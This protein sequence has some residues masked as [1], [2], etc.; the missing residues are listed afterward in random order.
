[1]AGFTQKTIDFIKS[2]ISRRQDM[3]PLGEEKFALVV[4]G[5][6]EETFTVVK[7][8]TQGELNRCYRAEL[9]MVSRHPRLDIGKM[10]MSPA[11]AYIKRNEGTFVPFS[12]ILAELEE[13]KKVDDNIFYRAVFVPKLWLLTR[14]SSNRIFLDITIPKL[15]EEVLV[16]GG[17]TKNEFEFRLQ[18]EYPR[19]WEYVC[20]YGESHF[21][22]FSRWLEYAGMYFYLEPTDEGEKLII[23]DTRI[24]HTPPPFAT[25]LQYR[26]PAALET[27]HWDELLTDFRA[28]YASVPKSVTLKDYNYRRPS[29]ELTGAADISAN[30]AGEIFIYGEHFQTPE[31]A[32]RVAKIRAEEIS[33]RQTVFHGESRAPFLRPGFIF[34]VQGHYQEEYNRRYMVTDIEHHGN[35]ATFLTAG[36]RRELAEDEREPFYRNNF[37]A[38]PADVQYRPPRITPKPRF[39]GII[40]AHIDAE[41]SGEYAELDNQGRYKV[42]LPFDLSNR[43]GGKASAWFRMAQPYAGSKHGMHFPLLKGTEVLLAFIDGDPDRP[44]ITGAV[45]NPLNP[46]VINDESATKAGFITPGGSSL[47]ADDMAGK[48]QVALRQGNNAMITLRGSGLGS[49]AGTWS[50]YAWH[51]AGAVEVGVANAFTYGYS[52][53]TFIQSVGFRRQ[54]LGILNLLTEGSNL[55]PELL[56]T[57][58]PASEPSSLMEKII[59][60]A[61]L[62]TNLVTSYLIEKQVK[63][64]VKAKLTALLPKLGYGIYTDN[65]GAITYMKAPWLQDNPDI[66]VTSATG[67]I[68]V[69]A[70]QNV[71]I[72]ADKELCAGADE[73]VFIHAGQVGGT[74]KMT[75]DKIEI[76]S[77]G[78]GVSIDSNLEGV[79]IGTTLGDIKI[80]S[81]CGPVQLVRGGAEGNVIGE[82]Q[83]DSGGNINIKSVTGRIN[84]T[85]GESIVKMSAAGLVEVTASHGLTI[86][87]GESKV[88]I[89]LAGINISSPYEVKI[90]ELQITKEEMKFKGQTAS[91]A[92][93]LKIK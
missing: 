43:R 19:T 29:L 14:T 48:E 75:G 64:R 31:E 83:I 33:C 27:G 63:A 30:G 34:E 57:G 18:N 35:Q 52:A 3:G 62:L 70:G 91:I 22:F 4:T 7:F 84:M 44:I 12:G 2:I 53:G 39:Y 23:T 10:L 67:S 15:L 28:C 38:I 5:L 85:A 51:Y 37:A 60:I 72:L 58:K 55:L 56:P 86:T 82:V 50:N 74:V 59:P 25:T 90:N 17:L 20:Q 77:S 16:D 11:F 9:V 89:E 78:H 42:V 54:A 32:N 36:L 80:K 41:S 66:G 46:S 69:V 65:T 71:N 40:N 21:D 81:E 92:N 76:K 79:S 73:K 1:M 68:D 24:V 26:L 6:P 87:V 49:E 45:P 93:V 13:M 47:V 8:N 61:S 88:E